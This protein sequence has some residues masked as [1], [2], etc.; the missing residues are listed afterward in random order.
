MVTLST[1]HRLSEAVDRIESQSQ[2]RPFKVVEMYCPPGEDMDVSRARHYKLHPE[3]RDAD[4]VIRR[5]FKI[6]TDESGE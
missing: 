6:P 4:V 5:F 2:P 1:I 3:D